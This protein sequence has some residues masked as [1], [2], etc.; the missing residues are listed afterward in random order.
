MKIT[1]CTFEILK[2]CVRA[3]MQAMVTEGVNRVYLLCLLLF[4]FS[5]AITLVLL[6]TCDVCVCLLCFVESRCNQ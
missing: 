6:Y 5:S 1:Y 2:L 4:Y 3:Y